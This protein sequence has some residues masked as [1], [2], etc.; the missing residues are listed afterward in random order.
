M[1]NG[2][3]KALLPSSQWSSLMH[4]KVMTNDLEL[5][6]EVYMADDKELTIREGLVHM[7]VIPTSQIERIAENVVMLKI[8]LKELHHFAVK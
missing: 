1:A 2:E 8:T 6:G 4:R 5:V 3:K 7:F